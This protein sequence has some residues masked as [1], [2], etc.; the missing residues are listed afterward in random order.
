MTRVIIEA[1]ID[2]EDRSLTR[3]G[4]AMNRPNRP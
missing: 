4:C 2:R 1:L 3:G